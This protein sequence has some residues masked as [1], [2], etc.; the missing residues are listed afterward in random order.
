MLDSSYLYSEQRVGD[1]PHTVNLEVTTVPNSSTVESKPSSVI[2]GE[3]YSMT[4]QSRNAAGTAYSVNDDTYYITWTC[5]ES[6]RCGS[7]SYTGY[8]SHYSSGL[9]TASFTPT[10]AGTYTINVYMTNDYTAA[11]PSVSTTVSGQGYTVT[12]YPGEIDP[13][14]CYTN[15]SG[16]PLTQASIAYNFYIYFVDLWDN[17]HYLTLTDDISNGMVVTVVA[18]YVN[19]DNYPSNLDVPDYPD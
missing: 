9:Y 19:H 14:K 17:L 11:V 6:A 1:T 7:T 12:V 3:S 18:D 5:T 4:M 16:S 2:A 8:G 13:A 15:L 10:K